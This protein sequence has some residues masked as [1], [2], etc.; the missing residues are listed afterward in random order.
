[1]TKAK[2]MLSLLL[3]VIMI[4][5]VIP[6]TASAA[7]H[8]SDPS[9]GPST[10]V[11]GLHMNKTVN[12]AHNELTLEAFVTGRSQTQ[13]TTIP[14]DTALVLD[15][16]GSM[17]DKIEVAY[18]YEGLVNLD[19]EYGGGEGIYTASFQRKI[20]GSWTNV[21]GGPWDLRYNTST[22]K[23]EYDKIFGGW[24][25]I[26]SNNYKITSLKITK[27][28]AMKIATK[29]F[30]D[31]ASANS[32]PANPNQISI[33]SYATESTVVKPLTSVSAADELKSAI[34]A[35]SADGG[36]CSDQGM[37]N[38]KSVLA[39][40]TRKR[41]AIMFTD[42]NPGLHGDFDCSDCLKVANNTI[43]T[44]REMKK[45]GVIVYTVGCFASKPASGSNSDNY[46][47]FTSSNYPNATSLT[48]GGKK[49]EDAKYYSVATT[50]SELTDIF[51][52]ISQETGGAAYTLTSSAVVQDVISEY[53]D[54]PAN[55]TENDI[56]VYT[57][58]FTGTN[59]DGSRTWGSRTA[60]NATVELDVAAKKLR[61]S[62][63]DFSE[64][65]VGYHTNEMSERIAH[66]CKLVIVIPIE[67]IM[68]NCWG[69]DLPTNKEDESGIYVGEN[70]V[71][72][73]PVP[74]VDYPYYEIVHVRMGADG[75]LVYTG[76]LSNAVIAD[77]AAVNAA[78]RVRITDNTATVDLT[79]RV[80]AGYLYGGSFSNKECT[81]AQTYANGENPAS[82]H[83]QNGA[84]YYI[85][86]APVDYLVPKSLS[87]SKTID[88]QPN[89]I[90]FY[91][92]T[93]VDRLY[94]QSAGFD[95]TDGSG[96]SISITD[97]G[98]DTPVALE[99][100]S[101][102][103]YTSLT[104]VY[105]NGTSVTYT[106]GEGVFEP[107][108]ASSYLACFSV[109]SD[110][111]AA[112]DQKVVFTPYWITLDGMKVTGTT[113]RTC[114]SDGPGSRVVKKI[115]EAKSGST[116][117]PANTAVQMLLTACGN[118]AVDGSE[119]APSASVDPIHPI[120]P[121]TPVDPVE[122]VEPAKQFSV[123]VYDGGS[124]Y[125]LSAEAGE[126]ISSR[127]VSA[128]MHGMRFAGWFLDERSTAAAEL[129]NVQGDMDVYAKYVSDTYLTLRYRNVGLFRS[130]NVKLYAALDSTD[131]AE[132][133]F[134]IDGKAVSCPI[135]KDAYTAFFLYGS[136]VREDNTLVSYTY[137]TSDL[138]YGDTVE[139][140]PYWVTLDG[141]TVYGTTQTLTYGRF[142]LM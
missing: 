22:G 53:F 19:T 67:P 15:V 90:G 42:G 108:S 54:L 14:V 35:L 7:E 74:T 73:F 122:P 4:L 58:A 12:S 105:T 110:A 76:D 113:T 17:S 95:V 112:K 10:G 45:D 36:T 63:F 71:A 11:N 13:V 48:V 60:Y 20:L 5:S 104:T 109:P 56:H 62:N 133:G 8:D 79:T 40:K 6:I 94:Y 114:Q 30:I 25:E 51:Q 78:N 18:G 65:W 88:G 136:T 75:K 127:L 50:G 44:S 140:T 77:P 72:P 121:V 138:R 34:D 28:N 91:L 123:T 37:A 85:W 101:S 115:A 98:E 3:A 120:D 55:T 27:L 103:V 100:G 117:M 119:N 59:A 89:V 26:G 82:F 97:V 29:H 141:T 9:D 135:T 128:G 1:M 87:L 61:V 134:V 137:G 66:G 31:S 68:D 64:N 39:D 106:P 96:N 81:E 2:R 126:D 116:I 99:G 43:S 132:A 86:E 111:W 93:G 52:T 84:T 24:T 57:Q 83:P 124:V 69:T 49:V 70:P 80:P 47:N 16:S 107:L 41:V 102:N 38:A 131:Y 139:I 33:I 130:R 118:V 129:K 142:G 46:M 125:T 92:L 23:W 32:D 21:P